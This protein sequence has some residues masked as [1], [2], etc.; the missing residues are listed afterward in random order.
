MDEQK[1]EIHFHIIHSMKGGCGKSTCA[2]IKTL[3]LANIALGKLTSITGKEDAKVLFLDADFKGSAMQALLFRSTERESKEQSETT[4]L[5]EQE[6]AKTTSDAETV[7]GVLKRVTDSLGKGEGLR[8]IIAIPDR[9]RTEDNLSQY[10]REP[11]VTFSSI[12]QKTF[13]YVIGMR[14]NSDLNENGTDGVTENNILINGYMDFVLAAVDSDSKNRFRNHYGKIAPGVFLH[15]MKGLLEQIS[16]HKARSVADNERTKKPLGQYE[17][18]VIDM[19]PGYDEY[20]DML[21]DILRKMA[22]KDERIK[23]HYYAVTTEDIG[24]MR[25]TIDNIEKMFE[26]KT[27]YK[28]LDEV[29]AVLNNPFSESKQFGVVAVN[30]IKSVLHSEK[31]KLYRNYYNASYHEYSTINEK[32]EF[33]LNRI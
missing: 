20:S 24:H 15:R 31:G 9:Y 10:L 18:V 14:E 5:E 33:T 29:S 13:S 6:G 1:E 30:S 17:D 26:Y 2:L 23:L 22:T 3:R 4:T 32:S 8:H 28:P 12:V 7:A 25:L 11:D 16:Y 19:P 21:L 27:E